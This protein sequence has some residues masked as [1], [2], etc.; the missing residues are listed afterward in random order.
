MPE[1]FVLSVEILNGKL[2]KIAALDTGS[3][4]MVARALHK[5][6]CVNVFEDSLVKPFK[7][8]SLVI[9]IHEKF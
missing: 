6:R 4:V 3:N 8:L 5:R 1:S 7:L 9:L 2:F